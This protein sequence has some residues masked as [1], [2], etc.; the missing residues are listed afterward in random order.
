MMRIG[1][2][3][4][5][6]AVSPLLATKSELARMIPSILIDEFME[7]RAVCGDDGHPL[8]ATPRVGDGAERLPVR[9]CARSWSNGRMTRKRHGRGSRTSRHR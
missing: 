1:W 6:N 2:A 3:N 5:N 9:E 7:P 8:D 4:G